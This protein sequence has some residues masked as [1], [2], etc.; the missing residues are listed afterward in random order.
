[1]HLPRRTPRR[2]RAILLSAAIA[3]GSSLVVAPAAPASANPNSTSDV[4]AY[5]VE[6]TGDGHGRGMS[7]WG[8]YG[9]AVDQ[10]WSWEQILDH[11][12]GGTELGSVDAARRITVRLTEWDGSSVFGVV[13]TTS[14]ARWSSPAH[15]ASTAHPAVRIVEAAPNSFTIS[16]ASAP[17]CIGASTL[18]VPDGPVSVGSTAEEEVER[19]Q[20]FLTA[21]GFDPRG[22]DGDYGPL[23]ES[24]V[25]AFQ[26]ANGLPTDGVWDIDD[27][28]A[29]RVIIGNSTSDEGWT[30][31]ASGVPGPVVVSTD[32]DESSAAPGDVLGLCEASGRIVH[33][34][35]TL[36]FL[37]NDVGNRVVNDVSVENYLRGVVPREVSPSWG[38]RGDGRGMNALRAQAVAARGYGLEQSRY[39][40][41]QTCDTMACQVYG[42]SATR[43]NVGAG[44]QSVEASQTD[45]AIAD[46][47]GRVRVWAAGNPHGIAPGTI[48][49]TEFSASN[50]PQ[51]AGGAFPSIAD[52]ADATALNPSHRW[53]RVISVAALRSAYSGAE[54]GRVTTVVDPASPYQGIYAN[55]V[56][57]DDGEHVSAWSFRGQFGLPSPGF[58]LSPITRGVAVDQSLF[59]IGDSV[60][61]SIATELPA[62]MSGVFTS[63]THDAL[64]SRRTAGGSVVPDGVG[65]AASV[66]AGTD[67]VVVELGYNDDPDALAGRIDQVMAT[68]SARGVGVVIWTTMSERRQANGVSRYAPA[69]AALESARGRWSNLIV[70]DWAAASD[71]SEADRWYSDGVHLTSTGQAEFALWLRSRILEVTD[72]AYIAVGELEQMVPVTPARLL[73]TR[74]GAGVTSVGKV[75]NGT[76]E[77]QV[78]GEGGI[79]GTAVSAVALNVTAV[80]AAT[81]QSGGYLTVFP[82]GTRPNAS[83]L[84]FRS[85]QTIANSVIAPV[86]ARGTVCFYVRGAAHLLADVSAYFPSSTDF[87]ALNPGRVLDTRTGNGA[88]VGSV[89]DSTIEVPVLGREGLPGTGVAAV[90]LN[91]TVDQ[92]RSG[93]GGGFVTVF[94]CGTRPNS[95]NL[96]FTTGRTIA[97]AV[98]APVSASGTV[99]I[100]VSGGAHLIADVSGYF[101]NGADYTPLAPVRVV[102]TRSTG[103]V[104]A[105][106]GSGGPLEVDLSG[107]PGVDTSRMLAASLNITVVN[108]RTSSAGGYVT[109][110]P[111]RVRPNASNVNFVTGLT[112]ANG[113]IAPVSR[114]GKVCIYVYGEADLLVDVN[115][116]VSY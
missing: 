80:E 49:S 13:S 11:Y 6:G 103:R 38:D 98:I 27:A 17:Q 57:L 87:V 32:V 25:R 91:L 10:G 70:V 78:L 106:D 4:I 83:N 79:P 44:A 111:C 92:A 89:T 116:V 108:S 56:R 96:N 23:T 29:A 18:T 77:V 115:G 42:G 31:V 81:D 14:S 82:C 15:S 9:W 26:I 93:P 88:P 71:D 86:S 53:T 16:V 101:P 52:P 84:N 2:R 76:I 69:N 46:T 5:L 61:A 73:D 48:A 39:V 8:A 85:G 40:Y 51:T 24:A 54:P 113:V 63:Y 50:G 55:R 75:T 110:Y 68:L 109:V 64:S 95:S 19:I 43:A 21:V 45:R 97:N 58:T 34:R 28:T 105:T 60:G 35:G 102:D 104:G 107:L 67:I 59:F 66:P 37:H 90:A 112:I 41:A 30:E 114:F 20:T 47:A 94:P 22:I 65:A 1:M 12:Y 33:Y 99:C 74:T 36:R 72:P 3:A 7:Q 62:L 100:Y